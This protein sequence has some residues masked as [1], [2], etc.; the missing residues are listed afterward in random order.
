MINI[1]N[2]IKMPNSNTNIL[3]IG[4]VMVDEY[5]FGD[6]KRISPEYPV[7][8]FSY[9]YNKLVLGGA[10]NV[11]CNLNN[12][13][14]NV[15]L[16]SVIG[17]DYAG[18]KLLELC[19]ENKINTEKIFIDK[20]RPTTVKTRILNQN[21]AQIL[22]IDKELA[23]NIAHKHVENIQN[24]LI[25]EIE[26]YDIIL[27]SD[28]LKGV[29]T[30]ELTKIIIDIA[31]KNGV[32]VIVD[33][34]GDNSLKYCGAFML[35]PNLK[36]LEILSGMSVNSKE[37]IINACRKI[38]EQANLSSIVVTL[39]GEGMLLLSENNDVVEIR[40][41][42]KEVFDVTG[43][44]DTVLAYLGAMIANRF[45]LED[46]MEI[47]NYAAGIKVG[48]V[49]TKPVKL[50]DVI[51][52]IQK[53]N[54]D[55]SSIIARKFNTKIL[56]KEKLVKALDSMRNKKIIFTNGCFDILHLGHISYL[57]KAKEKGD[58][59]IV[60]VNSD[61]SV[62]RLKGKNRPIIDE[63][64]R[65]AMLAS[66]ECVDYVVPFSEDTPL[67]LIELLRPNIL[68]KGADYKDKIVIGSDFVVNNGGNVELLDFVE[69]KSTTSIVDK[70]KY[71]LKNEE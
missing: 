5:Y 29:L 6:I 48:Y 16:M 18:S 37:K 39:G 33:V 56:A 42:A 11:A 4:D 63:N 17:D 41:K 9:K 46:A 53:D 65:M 68:V 45:S 3:V 23:E 60:G 62:K 38:K 69:G 8:V 24:A 71:I 47:A 15:D 67:E 49:G 12:I 43:A 31:N 70:I 25:S 20:N 19:K 10:S 55:Y 26:K 61:D 2:L 35:K 57:E 51:S 28:Y 32:K 59:L 40:T 1:E 66:L 13:H 7:P 22:R 30:D 27:L 44:G 34:K 14:C 58:L 21:G 50:E 36:E 52:G 64:E 54:S